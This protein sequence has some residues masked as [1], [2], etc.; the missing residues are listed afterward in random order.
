MAEIGLGIS[1]LLIDQSGDPITDD[2]SNALKVKLVGSDTINAN[3]GDVD[4]EFAGVAASVDEG[5]ADSGTLR[6]TIADDDN[7]FGAVG[8]T[9]SLTGSI[10]AQ[11]RGIGNSLSGLATSTNQT[12]IRDFIAATLVTTGVEYVEGAVGTTIVVRNDTLASLVSVDHDKAPLQ[13]NASGALYVTSGADH[14]DAVVANGVAI[15]GEAKTVDGSS[16]PNSTAEG[17]ATRIATTRGGVLYACL[18]D[19]TGQTA[20]PNATDDSE[21]DSTPGMLNVG[22]EYRSVDTTYAS[23]D[24]TILQTNVNGALKVVG[25][26]DLGSTDNAVL[27]AMVVDLAA[28]E[29]LLIT[30]DADTDAIKTAVEI[31]DNSISGSEMQV[32]VVAALPAGTNAIGKLAANSGVDI[33]DVDVTSIVPGGSAA[34]LGKAIQASQGSTDTGVAMLAVRKDVQVDLAD[35]NTAYTPLQ[36]GATGALY[37]THGMT[38]MVS[39]VNN[40]VGT[41]PEDLRAAGDLSCRRVDMMASPSNTGYIWVGDSSVA[42]DGTGGGIRLAPGDFYSVDVNSINDLHVAATVNGEDI[43]YTYHT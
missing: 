4:M 2:A 21:Q 3:I 31:L 19:I 37:T 30:I 14:D 40:D 27:D 20:P 25:T 18:T 39:E 5:N 7:H 8:D 15:L 36:V 13:V 42:N 28:M 17:D 10:H 26:V 22:G 38:A 9:A 35:G 12:T 41:S 23:G 16:L 6:I 11:L 32:D 29:A 1:R 43:M 33:G 24:A 34:N